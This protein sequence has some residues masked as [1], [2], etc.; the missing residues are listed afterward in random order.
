MSFLQGNQDI[1]VLKL[2]SNLILCEKSNV[3]FNCV[4]NNYFFFLK[5][6]TF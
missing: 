1:L 5:K 3:F 4:L 2:S 6:I